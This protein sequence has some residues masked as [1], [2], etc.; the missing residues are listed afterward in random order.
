[1]DLARRGEWSQFDRRYADW[2]LRDEDQLHCHH[3][4]GQFERGEA[5]DGA[6]A[7]LERVAD[8]DKGRGSLVEAL[9]KAGRVDRRWL[10]RRLRTAI[11]HKSRDSVER[12]AAL[13]SLGP[14]AVDAAWTRPRKILAAE[15]HP[16]LALI[17]I[18]RAAR[19]EPGWAAERL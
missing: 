16:Q 10:T 18:S 3:W 5:T 17:A 15:P 11:E 19:P 2:A 4:L 9:Y 13:L 14:V 6:R 1:F 12:T 7:I 8:L